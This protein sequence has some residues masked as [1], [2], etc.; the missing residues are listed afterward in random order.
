MHYTRRLSELHRHRQ[1]NAFM[2]FFFMGKWVH[3]VPWNLTVKKL[4]EQLRS[5]RLSIEIRTLDSP[6]PNQM[7]RRL[8]TL[9]VFYGMFTRQRLHMIKHMRH[10]F[11]QSASKPQACSKRSSFKMAFGFPEILSHKALSMTSWLN[12]LKSTIV[13]CSSAPQMSSSAGL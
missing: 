6:L 2:I 9:T 12:D 3:E 11:L 8:E 7:A 13:N 10:F 5:C 4:D 1:G